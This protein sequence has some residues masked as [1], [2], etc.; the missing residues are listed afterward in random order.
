MLNYAVMCEGQKSFMKFLTF[1]D[2]SLLD[3]L[4]EEAAT[5]VDFVYFIISVL[6]FKM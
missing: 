6:G 5:F 1:T 4:G 3:D 2:V